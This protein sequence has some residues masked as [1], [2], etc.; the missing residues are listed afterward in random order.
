MD[1]CRDSA[2]G[3]DEPSALLGLLDKML[4]IV[5]SYHA[6][7]YCVYDHRQR[8]LDLFPGGGAFDAFMGDSKRLLAALERYLDLRFGLGNAAL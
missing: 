1:G 5:V 3:G 2:A 8:G 4:G 7:I 6:P